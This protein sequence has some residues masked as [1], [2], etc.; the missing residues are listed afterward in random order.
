MYDLTTPCQRTHSLSDFPAPLLSLISSFLSGIDLASLR[1]TSKEFKKLF[2]ELN[3]T[4]K[5][6]LENL[7]YMLNE[8]A[9][10]QERGEANS[11][12]EAL[13]SFFLMHG[14]PKTYFQSRVFNDLWA[15]ILAG[16]NAHELVHRL[17]GLLHVGRE[18]PL[19]GAFIK[20]LEAPP[21]TL[22]EA[23]PP[24][25]LGKANVLKEALNRLLLTSCQT[26]SFQCI[27]PIIPPNFL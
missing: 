3:E 11:L 26:T 16:C 24:G 15:K 27:P 13:G 18:D 6:I 19:D 9:S 25:E 7:P 8:D 12:R 17:A 4:I 21:Y 1:V 22:N 23:A 10:S 14:H 2:E 5:K 20:I